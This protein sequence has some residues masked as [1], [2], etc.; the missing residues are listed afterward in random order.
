MTSAEQTAAVAVTHDDEMA[1]RLQGARQ[2]S[3]A[4][5]T[6]SPQQKN[7]ALEAFAALL[8][9]GAERLLGEN[10][11]DLDAQAGRIKP[12]LYQRLKLDRGKLAQL[13]SGIRDVAA[14]EDPVG[15]VSLRTRLDDGLT[16]EKVSVPLGVI[17]IIFESRPDVI[18]QILSLAL[19][20]GNA[21]VLKGGS[22]ALHSNRAFMALVKALGDA[23][24]GC[25]PT[26]RNCSSRAMKFGACWRF[27]NT[28]IW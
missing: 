13:A 8:E 21:V 19:K 1:A 6:L 27:P 23:C 25:R 4:M 24:P 18:P 7:Q 20:S 3:W 22:E 14:L 26:G 9:S 15:R 12:A 17:A 28:S 10:Q 5:A 16:L 11:R 2:A